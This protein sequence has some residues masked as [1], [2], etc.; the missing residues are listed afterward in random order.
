MTTHMPRNDTAT[1]DHVCPDIRIHAIDIVQPPGIGISLI[2]D[3]DAHHTIVT[4][5]LPAKS[6]AETPKNV[7]CDARSEAIVRYPFP[8]LCHHHHEAPLHC[9]LVS[10]HSD[11]LL[12]ADL[13]L[14]NILFDTDC[15]IQADRYMVNSANTECL[16][17][18]ALA[19]GHFVPI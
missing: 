8:Q 13:R 7:S 6:S 12:F 5:A 3:M 14:I 15:F 11:C 17:C 10:M 16:L 2:A 9:S 18:G 4:A 1:L 19:R